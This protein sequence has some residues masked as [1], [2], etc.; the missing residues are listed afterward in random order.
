MYAN[1][2]YKDT[3]PLPGPAVPV[4]HMDLKIASHRNGVKQRGGVITG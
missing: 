1:Y 4:V 3:K 2:Q